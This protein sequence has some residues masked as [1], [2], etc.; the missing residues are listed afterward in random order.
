MVPP[1]L[2][3]PHRM[4]WCLPT[5]AYDPRKHASFRDCAAAELS[6]EARLAGGTWVPLMREGHPGIPEV[7]WCRWGVRFRGGAARQGSGAADN[8]AL[9]VVG[10]VGGA[11]ARLPSAVQESLP[12]VPR[13]GPGAG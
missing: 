12:R 4:V 7:K 1:P 13:A 5:G 6:E 11:S 9:S 8:T 10:T 2:Q 3:G